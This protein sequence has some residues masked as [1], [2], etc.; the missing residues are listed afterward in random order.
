M[1]GTS[2]AQARQAIARAVA[3]DPKSVFAA[4]LA[5][6]QAG[7]EEEALFLLEVG[8]AQNPGDPRLWQLLGL[9]HRNLGDLAR[10]TIALRRASSL[11]PADPP[12]AHAL[13][14]AVLEAG[15]PAAA[16]FERAHALAP[17]QAPVLLGRAAAYF[18]EG[19]GDVAMRQLE[20]QLHANPGW[21][22]GH[23]TLARVRW[24]RGDQTG[25]ADSFEDAL[26][27]HPQLGVLWR[28]LVLTLLTAERFDAALDAIARARRAVGASVTLDL[29][30][31]S[32][33][34]ESGDVAAADPRFAALLPLADASAVVRYVRHL[35]RAGRPAEAASAAEA[36]IDDA[37]GAALW[38]Y[39]AI[40]WRLIGDERWQ[41][42][43]G[44]RRLV[45]I[46][47]IA[48]QVGSLPALATRLRGLHLATHQ[49]LD[50]S[51]RGGTQTDG[52]LFSRIDPE[53]AALRAAID[54]ALADYVA[55]LP[56]PDPAHPFLKFV[57]R[58]PL[59]FAGSWSVRLAGRGRHV[60]HIH[61]AGWISSAFYAALPEDGDE[62]HAGWLAMGEQPD[63]GLDLPP[64]RLI[65]PKP[66]RLVLFPSFLWHGTRPFRDGERLTVAFD[67]APPRN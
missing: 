65:E 43:E 33:L 60:A 45:G 42:L 14:R 29:L 17:L 55:Q 41:W 34:S 5:A 58:K 49:P 66:G 36:A 19:Q 12:I 44:D 16:L 51:L 3:H 2:A 62:P 7:I 59:R 25:F 50:Q 1:S 11:A 46:Y 56:P 38:S 48:D 6:I 37:D 47:D 15:Q 13:A 20:D 40:A 52:P 27:T 54:V 30:E 22:E 23:A 32:A 61:S 10:A 21:D 9:I 31:A 53:I 63:L 26:R 35:L 4:G 39:L 24:M 18:A 28:E 57:G 8:T 64:L 67:I